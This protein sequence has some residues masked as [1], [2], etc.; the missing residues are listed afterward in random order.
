MLSHKESAEH[1]LKSLKGLGMDSAQAG[2]SRSRKEELSWAVGEVSLLRTVTETSLGMSAIKQGRKAALAVNRASKDAI[3]H[4]TG[5]L[6]GL[7]EAGVADPAY[8]YAPAQPR[9]EF[10]HGPEAADFP[11]MRERVDEFLDTVRA[12]YPKIILEEGFLEFTASEGTLLNSNGVEFRSRHG[13]Y[14]FMMIFSAKDGSRT[15]GFN[16]T[17]GRMKDLSKPLLESLEAESLLREASG[18]LDRKPVSEK[19]T[20]QLL[21]TPHCLME[22]LGAWL[23]YLGEGALLNGTSVF[24]DK[25]GAR[26]ASPLL[27]VR[28]DPRGE[29]FASHEFFDGDGFASE[30]M[31]IVDQGVLKTYLLSLYGA[32]KLGLARA[33]NS[34]QCL[35]VDAGSMPKDEMLRSVKRGLVMCRFSGGRP[36]PNGDFSGVAKNSYYVENGEIRYPV[37]ETMVSGNIVELFK[38][39]VSV[40]RE[41]VEFG[42]RTLPWMMSEG[43]T[44]SGK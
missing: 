18:Q 9:K 37:A 25:L 23:G 41:R 8:A 24:K 21:L 22:L 5:E 3:D 27:S 4:A 7:V 36:A 26:I 31:D 35:S 15:S 28:A 32:N 29:T 40:S 2:A 38:N 20:G 43:F 6:K 30:A 10:A 19:F 44:I 13:R 33:K 34:A 14:G 1:A 12:R 16:Y 39:L 11:K 17:H 42:V